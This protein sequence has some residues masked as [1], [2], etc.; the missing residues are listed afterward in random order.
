MS[1]QIKSLQD[2]VRIIAIFVGCLTLV[3]GISSI[4]HGGDLEI[5][6]LGIVVNLSIYSVLFYGAKK[7]DTTHLVV[8]LAVS[9]A[10]L[11]FLIIGICYFAYE[12]EK[13][14][15]Q[16]NSEEQQID[17]EQAEL[18]FKLRVEYIVYSAVSG[19]L[20]IFLCSI[21]IVVKKFHNELLRSDNCQEHGRCVKA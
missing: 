15:L 5:S 9:L 1:S 7:K 2:P 16:Q 19:V 18:V 13:L 21:M 10:E 8:W 11:V 12:S 3:V 6:I 20:T 14:R 4:V 17:P